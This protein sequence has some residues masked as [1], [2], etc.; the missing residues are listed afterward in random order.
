[1]GIMGIDQIELDGFDTVKK[2]I[3]IHKWQLLTLFSFLIEVNEHV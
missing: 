1:M 2:L 3:F